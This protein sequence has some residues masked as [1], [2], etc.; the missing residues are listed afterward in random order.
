MAT[1]VRARRRTA[2]AL[3]PVAVYLGG[4]YVLRYL[5]TRL[6][7]PPSLADLDDLLPRAVITLA[8]DIERGHEAEELR[9]ELV[10]HAEAKDGTHVTESSVAVDESLSTEDLDT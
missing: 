9:R 7:Q 6:Y 8:L 10:Q 2:V 4:P 5:L 1:R 3:V